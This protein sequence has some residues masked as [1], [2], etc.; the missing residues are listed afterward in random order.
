MEPALS[1]L[2]PQSPFIP[3]RTE[4][5]ATASKAIASLP[6]Y[7]DTET[8][9]LEKM[10]EIVEISIIDHDGSTLFQSLVKPVS[11][12]PAAATRVHGIGNSDV[13]KAPAWPILW[14]K[15]RS[16]LFGRLIAAYNAPFD[17]R[18]MQQTHS[19]YRLPWRDA[20]EWLDVMTLYSR[21]RG[22]WDPY[23]KSMRFFSLEDAGKFF[24]I[25]LE[26]THRATADSLL[27]RAILH[28]IAGESY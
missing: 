7:I 4:L 14:P 21:H 12:I 13:L 9:G 2:V 18:M 24:A 17:L 5:A 8:T 20:F 15:V 22:V 6:V 10:D 16:V 26:N 1:N 3:N 28:S 19:R 23:R 11:Q 25:N 27:T